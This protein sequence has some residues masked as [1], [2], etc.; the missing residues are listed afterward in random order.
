MRCCVRR[1]YHRFS[2]RSSSHLAGAGRML[3]LAA[4]SGSMGVFIASARNGYRAPF[5]D[6]TLSN[7]YRSPAMIS[8]DDT[9]ALFIGCLDLFV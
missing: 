9:A 3:A 1:A 4:G 7:N 6:D 5:D 8:S 2:R